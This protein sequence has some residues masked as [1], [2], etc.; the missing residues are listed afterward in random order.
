MRDNLRRRRLSCFICVTVSVSIFRNVES[1]HR[2]RRLEMSI[3][4]LA[5]ISIGIA[6]AFI[7]GDN[8]IKKRIREPAIELVCKW[9]G[10]KDERLPTSFR[11]M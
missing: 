10:P 6:A 8:Y 1:E 9:C 3:K 11:E 4:A 7:R 2:I 5:K